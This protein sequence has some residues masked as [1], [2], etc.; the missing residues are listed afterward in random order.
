MLQRETETILKDH[1]DLSDEDE[2]ENEDMAPEMDSSNDDSDE[3]HSDNSE[4][5]TGAD[6][7]VDDETME[8]T[9]PSQTGHSSFAPLQSTVS[10]TP[11]QARRHIGGY[12]LSN[13]PVRVHELPSD[14]HGQK[15]SY[16]EIS[17]DEEEDDDPNVANSVL[18]KKLYEVAPPGSHG[19]YDYVNRAP[20][21]SWESVYSEIDL[22]RERTQK[23]IDEEASTIQKLY[24]QLSARLPL[25]AIDKMIHLLGG[26]DNVAELSGRTDAIEF[27]PNENGDPVPTCKPYKRGKTTTK[28]IAGKLMMRDA[29]LK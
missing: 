15:R 3:I 2:L 18:R 28:N 21:E 16:E 5:G 1:L 9:D 14:T 17:D 13:P 7:R 26:R 27:V 25:N 12:Q 10:R 19:S 29:F 8:K 22:E 6:E 24:Y 23:N 20:A 4:I 11:I